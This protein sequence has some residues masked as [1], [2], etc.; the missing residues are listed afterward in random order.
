MRKFQMDDGSKAGEKK[1][2]WTEHVTQDG[3]TYYYNTVTS[4]STWDKPDELKTT[5]EVT[6]NKKPTL[7][8][9]N[10]LS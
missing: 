8:Y 5:G 2:L 4:Q 7:S 9:V 10:I 6:T 3:R 1:S